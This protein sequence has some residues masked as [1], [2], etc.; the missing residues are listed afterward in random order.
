MSTPLTK[1]VLASIKKRCDAATA[2]PWI[3]SIE[4]RD[5]PL[6]GES[7]ILRGKNREKGDLYL[8]G[9]TEDD[10]IF[11][12]NSRQDIPVLLNEIERLQE[13]LKSCEKC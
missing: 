3:P 5:H 11:I 6:G 9:G 4:G 12:A 2:G 13:E 10:Y 1:N 7:V 8:I